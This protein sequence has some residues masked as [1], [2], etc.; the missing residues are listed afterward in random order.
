MFISSN[1]NNYY[2]TNGVFEYVVDTSASTEEEI[3]SNLSQLPLS[4]QVNY[5]SSLFKQSQTNETNISE[6]NKSLKRRLEQVKLESKKLKT[7]HFHS[8][9]TFV[10][11]FEGEQ[12]ILKIKFLKM[13]K[14]I[15]EMKGEKFNLD[16]Q[17]NSDQTVDLLSEQIP[18]AFQTLKNEN[19]ELRKSVRVLSSMLDIYTNPAN[20]FFI[21]NE[22]VDPYWEL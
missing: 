1:P 19:E 18:L 20:D 15:E 16:S 14:K 8:T 22:V 13:A 21:H 17:S 9:E 10:N 5:S 11:V 12:N 7:Q 6:I 2:S 4:L 3:N